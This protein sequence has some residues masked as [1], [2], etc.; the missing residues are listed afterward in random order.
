MRFALALLLAP[1]FLAPSPARP[2]D[3]ADAVAIYAA[4][5]PANELVRGFHVKHLLLEQERV[6][7]RGCRLVID[8][9]DVELFLE[10]VTRRIAAAARPS[11]SI[12]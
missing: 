6:V 5:L 12:C 7:Y 9:P 8:P 2:L 11:I 1:F 4:L 10:L 3:D